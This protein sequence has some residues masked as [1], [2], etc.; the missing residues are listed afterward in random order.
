M[1]T[2]IPPH[3]GTGRDGGI[4]L[5]LDASCKSGEDVEL[6]C[7]DVKGRL[8][9][10]WHISEA[11]AQNPLRWDGT[12]TRGR[13]IYSGVYLLKAQVDGKLRGTGK[14]VMIR[15]HWAFGNIY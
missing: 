4:W 6:S 9:K 12:D 14:L 13:E 15:W 7:Y 5:R 8:I 2:T 3:I 1:C 10:R 11:M